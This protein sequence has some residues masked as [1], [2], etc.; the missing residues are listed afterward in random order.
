M[1]DKSKENKLRTFLD[2]YEKYL[3]DSYHELWQKVIVE[4]NKIDSYSV[5]GTLLSRQ[6][7]L[8]M[9]LAKAP[10]NWTGHSAPLFLRAMTDLHIALSWIML[11]MEDRSRK[12]ILHGLGEEK[13]LIEHYKN[14]L[15]EDPDI[16]DREDIEKLIEIKTL[17]IESQR[18]EF[19]VEVD[20]GNWSRL[21]YRKMSIESD[22]ESLY[23]FAYKPFSHASHNMWPHVSIYNG[24]HCM[25]PLHRHHLIPELLV[26]PLDMDFLYRSC[27]YVDKAYD[28]FVEKFTLEL[29][30]PLPLDWWY[31]YF[32]NEDKE[33]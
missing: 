6:V 1:E 18:R 10:T 14:L 5:I 27:K 20:L 11:D 17:W 4:P 26:F 28:L 7:T 22:C 19:L 12:Y 31:E 9:E 32:E 29:E 3:K 25:N 8:S 23:K 15:D 33:K 16:E 21:D 30:H 13:L 2:S 24:R